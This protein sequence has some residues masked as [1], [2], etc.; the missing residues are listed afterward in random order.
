MET[1]VFKSG[2][3]QAVRIPKEFRFSSDRVMIERDGDLIILKPIPEKN[4]WPEGYIEALENGS[5]DDFPS[6]EEIR[7]NDEERIREDL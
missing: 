5:A 7:A 4:G 6:L 3:S 1:T 2:G